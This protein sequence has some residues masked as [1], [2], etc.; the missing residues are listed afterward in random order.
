MMINPFVA[1]L[2]RSFTHESQSVSSYENTP[3]ADATE[4]AGASC[5]S[6]C[7]PILKAV[8]PKSGLPRV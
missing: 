6:I 8:V 3:V 1:K 2:R 5:E 4:R 7:S